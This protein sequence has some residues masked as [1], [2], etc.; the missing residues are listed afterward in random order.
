[1]QAGQEQSTW[2]NA[3]KMGGVWRIQNNQP[4]VHKLVPPA[5]TYFPNVM[6]GDWVL[7]RRVPASSDTAPATDNANATDVYGQYHEDPTIEGVGAFSRSAARAG[8]IDFTEMLFCTGGGR[9]RKSRQVDRHGPG[10]SPAQWCRSGAAT[11]QG[12]HAVGGTT[13]GEMYI[14][15]NHRGMPYLSYEDHHP[16]LNTLLYAQDT[17]EGGTGDEPWT[18]ESKDQTYRRFRWTRRPDVFVRDP[19]RPASPQRRPVPRGRAG[20]SDDGTGLRLHHAVREQYHDRH[21]RKGPGTHLETDV[22]G[23][24]RV[25][26]C[27]VPGGNKPV[28]RDD[29]SNL[30]DGDADSVTYVTSPYTSADDQTEQLGPKRFR[31]DFENMASVRRSI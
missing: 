6:G 7:L 17:W 30:L 31:M 29:A 15:H 25:L 12:S 27:H 14:G 19:E 5:K 22:V 3:E 8:M 11:N 10:R 13:N 18:R 4:L 21:E 24:S 2:I 16:D 20:R 9:L 28:Q 23:A 1:M 26:T